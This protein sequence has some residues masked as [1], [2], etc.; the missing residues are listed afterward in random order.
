MLAGVHPAL[1]RRSLLAAGGVA[2]SAVLAGC[3]LGGKQV[4]DKRGQATGGR[5]RYGL[6]KDQFGDLY[7]PKGTPRGTVVSL[8][9]GYW[10]AQYGLDLM[11]P[12]S[13]RLRDE[14]F[15]VWNLEYRRIDGGGGWPT[16]FEDVAAGIDHLATLDGV[17][18]QRVVLLGHS[19]GG[20]LATWAAC[21][22]ATTPGGAPRVTAR[23]VVSLAGVLDLTD[24]SR[25]D[26]GGGAIDTLMGGTPDTVP[27][28]YAVG[29]PYRLVPAPCPV[30]CIRGRD[31]DVVPRTQATAYVDANDRAGGTT[32][33][34]EVGGDHFTLIDPKASS[35]PTVLRS[36]TTLTGT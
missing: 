26:V 32:T 13:T 6:G 34:Q 28:R 5:H 9:G 21:R 16:T 36:V 17:D 22:S 3:G 24:G 2:A 12:I 19:A 11:Q 1:S 14:G 35:W 7:L 29:D 33:F 8:H 20:Q 4:A 30:A 18:R 27:S 23:G 25:G 31:D 10:Y 15:A